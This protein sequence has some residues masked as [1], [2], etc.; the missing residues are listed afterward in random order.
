[1]GGPAVDGRPKNPAI[2]QSRRV[3]PMGRSN[4]RSYD[5]GDIWYARRPR[6]H[7]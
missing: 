1:M 3:A 5:G 4:G 7:G 2:Y 6:K